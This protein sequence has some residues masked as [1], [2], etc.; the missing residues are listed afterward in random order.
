VPGRGQHQLV[1]RDP[2]RPARQRA[3][4]RVLVVDGGGLA[5]REVGHDD[6]AAGLEER[7][8]AARERREDRLD[9]APVLGIR[10]VDH[11]I[12][13]ARRRRQQ[14]GIVERAE[15]RLHAALAHLCGARRG[16]HQAHN[17]V[18]G[19]SSAAATEPPM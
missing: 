9:H 6:R 17:L 19:F 1:E 14:T 8:A 3:Q 15:E 13:L 11:G 7:L 2:R 16:A 10:G 4:R 5:G 12:R 18:P